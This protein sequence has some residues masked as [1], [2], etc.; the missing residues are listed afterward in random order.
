MS[1]RGLSSTYV[2]SSVKLVNLA[3]AVYMNFASGSIR[4]WTGLNPIYLDDD[5]GGGTYS[6]VGQFGV[7]GDANETTEISAKTLNLT[8]TGVPSN[9]LYTVF[10]DP[11]RG[12]N[13]CLYA[14]FFNSDYT[15]FEKTI[16]MRGW[17]DQITI[18]ETGD[19]ASLTLACEN[20]MV[21]FQRALELR[22]TDVQQQKLY[23]GDI[24]LSFLSQCVASDWYWGQAVPTT[25]ILT[26]VGGNSAGSGVWRPVAEQ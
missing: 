18:N 24:G 15:N 20:R 23:P 21:Q 17:M 2:S 25:Q 5:Y 12:R 10:T 1:T 22:Y 4:A 6:P 9:L 14:L 7:V 8:L 26:L 16:L 3:Y 19:N 13:M 11:Y